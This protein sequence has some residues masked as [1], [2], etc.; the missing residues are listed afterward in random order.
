MPADTTQTR[1]NHREMLARVHANPALLATWSGLSA[2]DVRYRT[3]Y[4]TAFVDLMGGVWPNL[5]GK[6]V[7]DVGCGSGRWLRWLLELGARPADLVGVD[8]SDAGFAE[9]HA[10]HPGQQLRVTDGEHLPFEDG[11]FDLVTQW[12]CFMTMPDDA[13]RHRVAAEM[14]RVLAPGG[15][16]FWVDTVE[17]NRHLSDGKAM[18]P[19]LFFPTLS[20]ERR[21]V[22]AGLPPSAGIALAPLRR[23]VGP[24][25]DLL[26]ARVTHLAARLGPRP[27]A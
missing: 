24:L 3:A 6:R 13:A 8:V 22:R 5:A 20:A 16:V 23:V 17:S 7:L 14:V 26:A 10:I 2:L 11:S 1:E 27:R 25:V 18:D 4:Q 21:P 9:A 12:V 15:Y 19:Q